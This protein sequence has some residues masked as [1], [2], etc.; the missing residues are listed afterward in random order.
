MARRAG[1]V[2]RQQLL[3]RPR[4]VEHDRRDRR[5]DGGPPAARGRPRAVRRR[6]GEKA[7][8]L[9]RQSARRPRRAAAH[10]GAGA[11]ERRTLLR[12]RPFRF[13]H[14]WKRPRDRGLDAWRALSQPAPG[15]QLVP[16]AAQPPR[17]R[18]RHAA[19]VDHPAS[20]LRASCRSAT[21]VE[22]ARGAAPRARR[23]RQISHY[24]GIAAVA[25]LAAAAPG[26]AGVAHSRELRPCAWL[27]AMSG[28]R[29]LLF[30]I[31]FFG[32]TA[33]LGILGLP[34]LLAPRRT[35]MAFGRFWARC[36]LA[37]ARAIVGL[38]GEIRGL[39]H[40]PKGAC[41]IAMKH[42]SAWDT[43]I[44]PV[45]LGEPAVV[46]KRELLWV[47]FYGWYAARAGSIAI[48]RRGGAGALRRM[49]ADARDAANDGRA[50][51]IFPEGTRTAPGQ[52][53][54][55]QP[56]VAALYQALA[57]PLVPAAVN[58]GL[59]WGRRSFVKRPGRIVLSFLDPIPPGLP[60]REVRAEL[61]T[62]IETAT[63]ALEAEGLAAYRAGGNQSSSLLPTI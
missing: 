37:L 27:R 6:Q 44:L 8:H 54:T 3:D 21:L 10:A 41:L 48:D 5:R 63:A 19:S 7:V 52:R 2:C 60:R 59:Y 39:E 34:L 16:Y 17:I 55:Y 15:H 36:V 56:G 14:A 25:G 33:L 29:A 58:S 28:L 49:L 31:A 1:L 32:S 57:L 62:R 22:P 11:R 42:Q 47:P 20:G 30:N 40:L 18:A 23:V 13:R 26:R 50:I 45:V 43:L 24:L 46:I 38:D 4:P 12:D 53:L 61:E 9:R 35:V 51:V